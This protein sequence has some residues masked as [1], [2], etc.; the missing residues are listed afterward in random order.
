MATIISKSKL[1]DGDVYEKLRFLYNADPDRFENVFSFIDFSNK[2]ED[3]LISLSNL[4]KSGGDVSGKLKIDGKPFVF[5][6][7]DLISKVRIR[8]QRL[9]QSNIILA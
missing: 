1:K 5:N 6:V 8:H 4:S 2:P 3:E 9:A 7:D